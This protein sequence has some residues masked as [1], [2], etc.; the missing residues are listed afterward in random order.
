M[1]TIDINI[2]SQ[3]GVE[4]TNAELL[5]LIAG[6]DVSPKKIYRVTDGGP[7]DY[8]IDVFGTSSNTVS[9]V[10][11]NHGTGEFGYYVAA[12]DVFTPLVTGFP[13]DGVYGQ[14]TISGAGT[15]W[16][17]NPTAITGQPS[18][19]P[20]LTDSILVNSGGALV[21]LTLQQISDLI[22]PDGLTQGKMVAAIG[23]WAMQ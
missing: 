11:F 14:I 7:S 23:G 15:I 10:A 17:L 1:A 4:V 22:N 5:A 16:E 6:S 3:V 19:T 18:G 20:A 8:P 12:T 9:S 21:E 13:P 2:D